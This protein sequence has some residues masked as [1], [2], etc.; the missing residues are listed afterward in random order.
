M[1]TRQ[2]A[3]AITGKSG[4]GSSQHDQHSNRRSIHGSVPLRGRGTYM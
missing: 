3:D 1:R 2:P 4:W